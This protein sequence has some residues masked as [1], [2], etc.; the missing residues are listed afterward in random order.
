MIDLI[1]SPQRAALLLLALGL[2]AGARAA[3]W[4]GASTCQ[5]CHPRAYEIWQAGP[6]AHAAQTLTLV[7]RHEASCTH[8]HAPELAVTQGKASEAAREARSRPTGR[9]GLGIGCESCHGPGEHYSPAYVMRDPE[10]AR[11]VG[12]QDP[13]ERSCKA[14]HT[15]GSPGLTPFDF[16][17]KVKLIDHWTAERTVP[18][19]DA[20]PKPEEGALSSPRA[21]AAAPPKNRTDKSAPKGAP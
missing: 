17:S 18:V 13:G 5:A 15:A 7:Q 4:V 21:E 11:A 14:C 10:L 1:A 8:C 9:E 19:G 16:A 2:A 3:D 6:H 12:L 20:A